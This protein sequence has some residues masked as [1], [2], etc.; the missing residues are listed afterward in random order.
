MPECTAVT[1]VKDGTSNTKCDACHQGSE[2]DFTIVMER[3]VDANRNSI[4]LALTSDTPKYIGGSSAATATAAGI[5]AMLWSK[6][7]NATRAQIFT[8]LRNTAQFYP[9][10]NGNLGWGKINAS[11]AMGSI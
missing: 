2:V 1:G 7:P 4:S 3:A 11:A 6:T 9:T 10:A 8:A 5:A